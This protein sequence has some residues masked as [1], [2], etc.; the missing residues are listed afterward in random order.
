LF[1]WKNIYGTFAT[2]IS[3][4]ALFFI[5]SWVTYVVEQLK[6]MFLSLDTILT[7]KK[8]KKRIIYSRY[9]VDI[10]II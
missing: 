5:I 2:L 1:I 8:K 10:S 4:I 6:Q 7:K 9:I 3:Q